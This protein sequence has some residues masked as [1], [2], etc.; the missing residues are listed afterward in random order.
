MNM[1]FITSSALY[2]TWYYLLPR[3]IHY[4]LETL[5]SP[6]YS[7]HMLAL[8]GSPNWTTVRLGCAGD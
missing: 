6:V 2:S 7:S 3:L 4:S 1:D 5:I 8:K